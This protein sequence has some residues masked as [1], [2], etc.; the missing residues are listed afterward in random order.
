[1]PGI[2]ETMGIAKFLKSL[3]IMRSR[4]I[5]LVLIFVVPSVLHAQDPKMT[6]DWSKQPPIITAGKGS[7]PPSDATILYRTSKD[8]SNWQSRNGEPAKWKAKE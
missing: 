6:E 2:P 4:I 7:K 8:L 5:L 1:M 3:S